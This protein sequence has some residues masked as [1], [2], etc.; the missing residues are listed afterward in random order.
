MLLIKAIH[1]VDY[2]QGVLPYHNIMKLLKDFDSADTELLIYATTLINKILNGVPDQDTY[3][4]QTDAL[5]EQGFEPV[6]QRYMSKQGTDLDL[7]QQFQIYEA[8]LQYED[9]EEDESVR[10]T[11][12]NRKSVVETTERRKSRRHSTGNTPYTGLHNRNNVLQTNKEDDDESSSSQSSGVNN[13]QLNGSYKDSNK[14]TPAGK[15]LTPLLNAVNK[16]DSEESLNKQPWIYSMIQHQENMEELDNTNENDRNVLL[17]LKREN[18]VK[19]LTQKLASQNIMHS[20]SEENKLNRIVRDD[21]I[22]QVRLKTGF[23]WDELT[24]ISVDTQKLEHLFESRAKD[25]LT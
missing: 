25:L 22:S 19:D 8:V 11:I 5:E 14:E 10:K 6:I 13:S 1:T 18:T 24:P 12:R 23:I 4:D 2:S 20:P 15:D 21:P 7:L 3:Y 17:Q 16:L 9:G